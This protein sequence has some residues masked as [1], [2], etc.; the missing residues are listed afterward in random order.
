MKLKISIFLI[1]SLSIL[2]LF[3]CFALWAEETHLLEP[4]VVY[5][6][7]DTDYAQLYN[8]KFIDDL[9]C[10]VNLAVSDALEQSSALDLAVRGP[11]GLQADLRMR[12]NYFEQTDILLDGVNINDPQT[13]HFNLDLPLFVEDMH[14][15]VIVSG[16][17]P[18][19]YGAGRP[20]GAVHFITKEPQGNSIST[21]VVFGEHN[22]SS[23]ALSCA[24]VFT[25]VNSQTTIGQS[26]SKGY[27]YNT[28]FDQIG[29]SHISSYKSEYGDFKF[30]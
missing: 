29:V 4:I 22:F 18:G 10:S 16:P 26:S 1:Y 24:Y 11:V 9:S 25:D 27:R 5:P 12:G 14:K 19:K 3:I 2:Q 20:G 21:K 8:A 30:N 17:A 7:R 23:Q 13:G 15:I 6:D 28:D